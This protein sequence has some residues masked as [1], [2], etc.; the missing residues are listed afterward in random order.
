MKTDLKIL[1]VD[2]ETGLNIVAD[3][4]CGYNKV[5]THKQIIKERAIICAAWKWLGKSKVYSKHWGLTKQDDT[6]LLVELQKAMSKADFVITQNGDKFDLR[7]LQARALMLGLKP[8]P[9]VTS[10]DTL[11][12]NRKAFN[13]NS[14]KLDYV[15]SILGLG[16]KSPME[17]QDWVDIVVHKS[18]KALDKMIKYNK[19]DVLLTEKVFLKVLPYTNLAAPLFAYKAKESVVCETCGENDT[20]IKN[21]YRY[22]K[23]GRKQIYFCEPCNRHTTSRFLE[24]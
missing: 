7:W 13:L 16:H 19:K 21:G 10:L 24:K 18:A 9:K 11:K 3:F 2:L 1:T 6:Q 22:T 8:F 4:S 17:F 14:Y 20:L 5:I 12:M 15:A 23:T